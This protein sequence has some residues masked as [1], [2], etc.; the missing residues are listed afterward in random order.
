[1]TIQL[2]DC[3]KEPDPYSS[4]DVRFS[5]FPIPDDCGASTRGDYLIW[6]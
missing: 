3:R 1:M 4:F 6:T 2:V 5:C